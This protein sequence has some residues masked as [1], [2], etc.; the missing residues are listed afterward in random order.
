MS[1]V[2]STLILLLTV[3]GLAKGRI[4]GCTR[5]HRHVVGVPAR[6][7]GSAGGV[8]RGEEDKVRVRVG[9]AGCVGCWRGKPG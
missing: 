8:C 4:K 3:V 6:R 2:T 1:R 7:R 9:E 5:R